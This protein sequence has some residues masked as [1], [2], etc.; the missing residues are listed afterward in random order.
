[1]GESSEA[2]VAHYEEATPSSKVVEHPRPAIRLPGIWREGFDLLA[3][4]V[5]VFVL[6]ELA[7][8]R[9]M[10]EGRSMQPNFQDGQRLIVSRVH[11]LFGNPG[12]GDIVVFNSP[13]NPD[14]EPLIKRVIGLP[15]ETVEIR[16]Q[17]VYVNGVP[18]EEPYI[19]EPCTPSHCRDNMWEL[20]TDEY[21]FMGDNRNH[22]NDSRRFGP[23]N[24]ENII[25]ETLI[26]YWPPSNW[27]IVTQI[28]FPAE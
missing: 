26:C 22:S 19:N 11:Y 3:M 5:L 9:F 15:G 23:V 14:G 7:I 20:G 4:V 18:L 8:P 1:M 12:R 25:G 21:F 13:R 27:G 6:V 2:I 28:G 17:M 24:Y 16:E 10:V